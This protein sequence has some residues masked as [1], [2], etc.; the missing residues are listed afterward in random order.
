MLRIAAIVG[1]LLL[2][3]SMPLGAAQRPS[4]KSSVNVTGDLVLIGDLVEH[5]GAFADVAIFRSPDLGTTGAVPV[6]RVRHALRPYGLSDLDTGTLSEV[7]VARPSRAITETEIENRIVQALAGQR[8]LGAAEDLKL[9]IDQSLRTIHIEANATA[10]LQVVRLTLDTYGSR[11]GVALDVPGS[12]ILRRTPLRLSGRVVETVET[13]VLTRSLQRGDI[14][15]RRDIAVERRPRIEVSKDSID[16]VEQAIGLAVHRP[17]RA[18]H[19]LRHA[20]LMR[21]Q[22]VQRDETV[23]LVYEVPGVLLTIRGKATEAGAEG[24]T[25]SVLNLQSKRTVQGTIVGPGRV[26]V[27]GTIARVGPAKTASLQS[28][29]ASHR[30]E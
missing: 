27:T 1:L 6:A 17:L 3:A 16:R 25:I 18:G 28:T 30:P 20:D 19:A 8:G 2:S 11:F 15:R 5:A 22:L 23:T 9:S 24:D 29:R 14:V 7:V 26:A 13:A 12:A 4:L 10:E 21:P